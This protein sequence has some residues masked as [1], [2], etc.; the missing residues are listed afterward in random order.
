MEVVGAAASKCATNANCQRAV[1]YAADKTVYVVVQMKDG[2]IYV[3]SAALVG[4]AAASDTVGAWV[5][6]FVDGIV[7]NDTVLPGKPGEVVHVVTPPPLPS[8]QGVFG[9]EIPVWPGR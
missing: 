7:G 8:E 4:I 9:S 5:S 1:T 2:V 3:G 6:Y